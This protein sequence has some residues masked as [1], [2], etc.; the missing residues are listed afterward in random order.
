MN[1]NVENSVSVKSK[2]QRLSEQK[3]YNIRYSWK[4]IRELN[5]AVSKC[6][7]FVNMNIVPN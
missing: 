1:Y 7:P 2:Y 3:S 5:L 4:I 6:L